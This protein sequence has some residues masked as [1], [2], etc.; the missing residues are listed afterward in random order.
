M[1]TATKAGALR[2][3]AARVGREVDTV[4]VRPDGMDWRPGLRTV[5]RAGAGAFSLDG[6]R[7][8][9]SRSHVVLD[10][11]DGRVRL[12]WLDRDGVTIHVTTYSDPPAGE[13]DDE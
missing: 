5:E 2:W 7:M 10:V 3:F 4:Q 11:S 13:D 8:E 12:E 6:S 1:R 9:I